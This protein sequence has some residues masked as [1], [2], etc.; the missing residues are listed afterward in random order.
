MIMWIV[1]KI[2]VFEQGYEAMSIAVIF[3]EDALQDYLDEGWKVRSKWE[4]SLLEGND[5]LPSTIVEE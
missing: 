1:E 3:N 4:I 2:T 5:F